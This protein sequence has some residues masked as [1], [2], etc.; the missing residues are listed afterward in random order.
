M[1]ETARIIAAA[2]T[3]AAPEKRATRGIFRLRL[4]FTAH[5]RGS[6]IDKRYMSVMMSRITTTSTYTGEFVGWQYSVH[7]MS[8][9]STVRSKT[10]IYSLPG[11]GLICQNAW[12]G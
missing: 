5:R 10:S 1:I 11:L 2:M 7:G 9:I 8:E 4:I 3:N 6:G 12:K